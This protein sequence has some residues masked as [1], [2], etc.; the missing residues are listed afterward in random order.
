MK[1][2]TLITVIAIAAIVAAL[3]GIILCLAAD[4]A[5]DDRLFLIGYGFLPVPVVGL[6]A[7]IL[8]QVFTVRRTNK[9]KNTNH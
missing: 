4:H 5:L 2:K 6:L 8:L 7:G 1:R 9:R 3:A